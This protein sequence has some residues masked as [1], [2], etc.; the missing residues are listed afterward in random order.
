MEEIQ[1]GTHAYTHQPTHNDTIKIASSLESEGKKCHWYLSAK[2]GVSAPMNAKGL[3]AQ[4]T[5]HH[6]EIT[7][8]AQ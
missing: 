8:A 6:Y 4:E 3:S 7:G 1:I 2:P 5:S